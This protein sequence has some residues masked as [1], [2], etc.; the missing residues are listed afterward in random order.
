MFTEPVYL[1]EFHDENDGSIM[2]E[3]EIS[4]PKQPSPDEN[5][6]LFD[7][8]VEGCTARYRFHSNL[9]RHYATGNHTKVV[10]KHS[11][12]DKSK[13]I[14]HRNLTTNHLR[15]TPLLSFTI[16]S[17]SDDLVIPPLQRGW[18]IQKVKNNI[19]FNEKQRS[20]LE[21][22]FDEGVNTGSK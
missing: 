7:C 19:R 14:F 5:H 21:S 8:L 6:Y 22:K 9:L 16:V 2:S 4:S 11:I 20:F 18:A 17:S 15:T 3:D 12:L 1:E 13:I 10:E